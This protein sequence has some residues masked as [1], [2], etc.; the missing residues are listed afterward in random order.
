MWSASIAHIGGRVEGLHLSDGVWR[1][2][3]VG[4]LLRGGL[5]QALNLLRCVQHLATAPCHR[6]PSATDE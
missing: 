4:S 5:H 2:L 1:E 3:T 6:P